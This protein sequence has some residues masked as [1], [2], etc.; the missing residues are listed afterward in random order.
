M[1]DQIFMFMTTAGTMIGLA[2]LLFVSKGLRARS[3]GLT[4]S[5]SAAPPSSS[6][7]NKS[8]SNV[9]RKVKKYTSDGKP[10]YED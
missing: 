3:A 4:T 9:G 7:D 10:I 5:S 2:A 1:A 8:Y 6:S